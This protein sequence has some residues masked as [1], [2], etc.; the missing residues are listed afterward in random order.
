MTRGAEGEGFAARFAGWVGIYHFAGARDDGNAKRVDAAVQRGDMA[1]VKSLRRESHD[2]DETCWLHGEGWCLSRR[3]PRGSVSV[4]VPKL[5][6]SLRV[7][8]R[9]LECEIAYTL[10]RMAVLERIPGNPVG[11]AYRHLEVGAV[12]LMVRH[13]PVPGFNSV[14]GLRAGHEQQIEP[15][16]AWYRGEGVKA[17]FETV[18]GY[19]DPALGRELA[20]LGYYQSGFHTSLV[21]GPDLV[22]PSAP[23]DGDVE[24]V[25]SAAVLEEFLDAY[26]AGRSIPQGA[27]FKANVRPWL[28]EPGWQLYLGRADG[29][30]AAAA[31]LFVHDKVGYCA[32]ATTD[33][34]FRGR[35]LQTALLTRRIAD[36]RAAGADF[37]C[38]GA[39]FLSQSHRNMERVGMRVQFVRALW[40]GL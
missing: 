32:D 11:I 38:S 7:V 16:I 8:R 9:T 25:E 33:P 5:I 36:A 4:S 23:G 2:Q 26:I 31:I 3:E 34:A 30:P 40:T 18:P 19:Y 14:V 20:R 15:L 37:V 6:P 29:R 10:S 24:R 27:Q 13:L 28:G 39:E 21:C 35:G 22:L 12:A 17:Q 1:T